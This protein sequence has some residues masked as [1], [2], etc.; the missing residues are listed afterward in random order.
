M[1]VMPS[2]SGVRLEGLWHVLDE[3]SAEEGTRYDVE[4]RRPNG[5]AD[6]SSVRIDAIKLDVEDHERLVLAGAE[7]FIARPLVYAELWSAGNRRACSALLE[8]HGY[9]VGQDDGE[10]VLFLPPGM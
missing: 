3:S 6:F 8:R 10:N 7:H 5:M 2:E 1:M 9:R 4:L